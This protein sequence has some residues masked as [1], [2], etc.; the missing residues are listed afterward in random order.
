M[1]S[2][3]PD[4]KEILIEPERKLKVTS[5]AREGNI[6]AVDAEMVKTPLALEDLIKAKAVKI[7]EKKSKNKEEVP[8]NLRVEN[9]TETSVELSWSN[10]KKVGD[11]KILSY[12]VSVRTAGGN[13]IRRNAEELLVT[14][15]GRKRGSPRGTWRWGEVYESRVR[16]KFSDVSF[17]PST[18][19]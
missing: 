12:Q 19:T 13:F 16:C 4:E 18:P 3:F 15:E 11:V 6:I 7:K 14:E 1:F 8:G 10:P 2:D 17:S 5:V 9:V